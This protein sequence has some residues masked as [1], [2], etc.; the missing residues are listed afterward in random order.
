MKIGIYLEGLSPEWGG[1]YTFQNEIFN[2]FIK[3]GE[4]SKHTFVIY[5][6]YKPPHTMKLAANMQFF[7]INLGFINKIRI[8]LYRVTEAVFKKLGITFNKFIMDKF[9]KEIIISSCPEI[10]L[11]FSEFLLI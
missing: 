9:I 3:L 11:S 8:K 1:A 10:I 6:F 2:S 5:S 7:Q 4:Q